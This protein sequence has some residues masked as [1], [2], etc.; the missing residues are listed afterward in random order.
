[1]ALE[2]MLA[3]A[4]VDA[5]ARATLEADPTVDQAGLALAVRSFA[6]KRAHAHAH[7]AHHQRGRGWLRRL[8]RL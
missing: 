5:D 6:R 7:R 1:M 8:F 3:Q 4:Y 2:A